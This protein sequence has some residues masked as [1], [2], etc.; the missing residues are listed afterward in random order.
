MPE[1]PVKLRLLQFPEDIVSAYVPVVK[2]KLIEFAP[3]TAPIV[4]VVAVAPLY[5]TLTV[6]VPVVE[7]L[8]EV[9]VVH[10]VPPA[11]FSVMFPEP[12]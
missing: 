10:R 6:C 8:V 1:K 11:P 12:N 2:L 9:A 7:K 3:L 4:M 5:D